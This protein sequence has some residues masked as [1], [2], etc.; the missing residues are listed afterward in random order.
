MCLAKTIPRFDDF[1]M[2][3]PPTKVISRH[4]VLERVHYCVNASM[5]HQY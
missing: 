5:C 3:I 4:S 2:L 1:I